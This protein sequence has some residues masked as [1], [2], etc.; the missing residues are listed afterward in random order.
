MTSDSKVSGDFDYTPARYG[1]L[2]ALNLLLVLMMIYNFQHSILRLLAVILVII[3]PFLLLLGRRVPNNFVVYLA[4]SIASMAYLT[5]SILGNVSTFELSISGAT[6]EIF[7]AFVGVSLIPTMYL[8]R[9]DLLRNI[10]YQR[11]LKY[12]IAVY[13]VA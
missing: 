12:L 10:D 6:A 2:W 5:S 3:L 7:A 9:T 13:L 1:R 4:L 11:V 8:L